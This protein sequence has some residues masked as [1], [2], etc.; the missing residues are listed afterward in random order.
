METKHNISCRLARP[1]DFEPISF[2]VYK[3]FIFASGEHLSTGDKRTVIYRVHNSS[4]DLVY[5]S[6]S[7]DLNMIDTALDYDHLGV[8]EGIVHEGTGIYV[9]NYRSLYLFKINELSLTIQKNTNFRDI[10]ASRLKLIQRHEASGTA[11]VVTYVG[12]EELFREK[13]QGTGKFI[14]ICLIILGVAGFVACV[15][16]VFLKD[17][18]NL[19]DQTVDD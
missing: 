9:H 14:Y 5:A 1:F 11:A 13:R 2:R 6:G 4:S 7:V 10:A 12:L 19:R 8:G 18:I 17:D 16:K 3:N 15:W